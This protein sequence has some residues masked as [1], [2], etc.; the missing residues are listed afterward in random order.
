MESPLFCNILSCIDFEQYHVESLA[1]RMGCDNSELYQK[2]QTI[3]VRILQYGFL[4]LAFFQIV[5]GLSRS[6]FP[7]DFDQST[8]GFMVSNLLLEGKN[9]WDLNVVFNEPY[10]ITNYGVF[11]NIFFAIGQ[12][13][14]G[15]QYFFMRFISFISCFGICFIVYHLASGR[16]HKTEIMNLNQNQWKFNQTGGLIALVLILSSPAFI[17]NNSIGR[18]DNFGM[19]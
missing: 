13:I 6:L 5:I 1:M 11:Y 17:M 9:P 18:P 3:T 7:Y 8:I 4:V 2:G 19:A 14:L 16:Y 12:M 10:C 15:E